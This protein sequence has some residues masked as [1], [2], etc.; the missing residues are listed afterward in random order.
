M[1][2]YIVKAKTDKLG[3]ILFDDVFKDLVD[4]NGA[5]DVRIFLHNPGLVTN[6]TFCR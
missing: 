1:L 5:I 4:Q 3:I 2:P 6:L